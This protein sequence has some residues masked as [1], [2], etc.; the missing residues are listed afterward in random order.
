MITVGEIVREYFP[1]ATDEFIEFVVWEKTGYPLFWNIPEDGENS[2]QCFRK[3]LIE[4]ADLMAKD[5]HDVKKGET[6]P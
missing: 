3:Q 6:E 5:R 4:Y 1:K 2:D